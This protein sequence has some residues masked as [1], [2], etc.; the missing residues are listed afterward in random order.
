MLRSYAT[1]AM[2]VEYWVNVI[3]TYDLP[4][5]AAHV[6]FPLCTEHF[7]AC[8]APALLYGL[9]A[10]GGARAALASGEAC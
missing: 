10:A 2:V 1:A 8:K 4:V 3:D 6:G 9:S 5:A 7:V